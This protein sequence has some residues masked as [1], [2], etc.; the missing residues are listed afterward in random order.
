M[1]YVKEDIE[2]KY[3]K[4]KKVLE[5]CREHYKQRIDY[6]NELKK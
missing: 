6:I 2:K 4:N 1:K 3:S 5:V